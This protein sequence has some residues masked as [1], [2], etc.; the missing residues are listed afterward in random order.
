MQYQQPS[1]MIETPIL[2]D[3]FGQHYTLRRTRD[4][5]QADFKSRPHWGQINDMTG[6][7]L[8]ELYPDSYKKFLAVYKKFNV[9]KLFSN[10]FT[11]DFDE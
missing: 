6:K 8:K 2:L 5:M 4:L 7:K 9:T 1:C 11:K 10:Y 3:T